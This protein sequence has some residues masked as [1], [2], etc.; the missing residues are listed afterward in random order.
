MYKITNV[1]WILL[2][3]LIMSC[4][5]S[6]TDL[7][8]IDKVITAEVLDDAEVVYQKDES[9]NIIL[10]GGKMANVVK[11]ASHNG[12]PDPNT[13]QQR[14]ETNT[15]QQQETN[16]QQQQQETNTQQQ[17][18][19][20]TQQQQETNTQQ[21]ETNTQ[22]QQETNTQQQQQETNTQQQW[23]ET[24]TQQQQQD[25]QQDEQQDQQQD[26]Q[27]DQQ[28]D[29]QQDQ[30]Q[31]EQQDQQQDEQQDQQQDEQQDQ[32]QDEQQDQQQDEQQDQQQDEQQDEQ[33]DQQQDEQQDQQQ[34]EQQDQQQ[35][36]Q[37]DQQDQQQQQW[38]ETNT[39]QQQE[40]QQQKQQQQGQQQ[41]A[42]NSQEQQETD[43]QQQQQQS[44]QQNSVIQQG[45]L[46][47]VEEEEPEPLIAAQQQQQ[48][49]TGNVR[50]VSGNNQT[51]RVGETSN[52]VILRTDPGVRMMINVP[53]AIGYINNMT[54][55]GMSPTRSDA[56][57]YV[58]FTFTPSRTPGSP[59]PITLTASIVRSYEAIDAEITFTILDRIFLII[60]D[61]STP[62]DDGYLPT[63]ALIAKEY[64]DEHYGGMANYLSDKIVALEVD[65]SNRYRVSVL[66]NE[67]STS[68]ATYTATTLSESCISEYEVE[69][70]D[71]LARL[72]AGDEDLIDD[73]LYGL[74]FDLWLKFYRGEVT[75]AEVVP[76]IRADF[77][78]KT[79]STIASCI[80]SGVLVAFT[81]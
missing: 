57:G 20:N 48:Q 64:V 13:Q 54:T 39:Q 71:F 50:V 37:Q 77:Q 70:V 1:L 5:R 34:D 29:E 30:Q 73:Y 24:N 8:S 2:L 16:T 31:D 65:P 45:T 23:Q 7:L 17:Q 72:D 81:P 79:A 60:I 47:F 62:S 55:P 63:A 18:E 76:I 27:Q 67:S 51:V 35:D 6:F 28:Q 43:T 3:C 25:Q 41:R 26:E 80:T 46:T 12:A 33:Q 75:V 40:Q 22:Q 59:G 49:V 36:E 52:L 10:V 68:N 69:S 21:Q 44:D 58:E 42:H 9:G 61:M 74:S 4:D 56:S 15:Q 19:T 53:S 78:E 14:Q 66:K 32:Q 11:V 38:Q